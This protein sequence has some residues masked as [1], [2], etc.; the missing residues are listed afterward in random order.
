MRTL[1]N[2]LWF[3][4]GGWWTALLWIC[5]GI[6]C[7]VTIVGIPIGKACFQYANLM[8][9]PFGKVIVKETFIK[10]KENV[11][12]I[13]RFFGT[14]VNILWLPIGFVMFIG[15]VGTIIVC[16]ISIIFIPVAVVVAKSSQFLLWP[17]GAK[18]ITKE[19]YQAILI[20]QKANK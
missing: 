12:G 8:A 13:R 10:G 17:V 9:F 5:L 16:C 20:A 19:E 4:L 7:C 15:S 11:S 1:G 6:L 2:I 3:V 18:V 14:L